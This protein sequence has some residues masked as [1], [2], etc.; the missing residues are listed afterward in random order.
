MLK[1]CLV[2]Y[3]GYGNFGDDV[4]LKILVD[5]FLNNKVEITVLTKREIKE[6]SNDVNQI[7]INKNNFITYIKEF[8]NNDLIIWGGG[9]C[10][11]AKDKNS[12]GLIGLLRRIIIT[13][14]VNKKFIFL[15]VGAE[16]P[17]SKYE[18][19]LYYIISKL[20]YRI[21][22]RDPYSLEILSK[23]KKSCLLINDLTYLHKPEINHSSS[24]NDK[25]MLVSLAGYNHVFIQLD[26][27]CDFIKNLYLFYG[28][29]VRLISMHDG[30][31]D[32]LNLHVFNKLKSTIN[33]KLSN[34]ST[35][36]TRLNEISN[37]YFVLGMRLHSIVLADVLNV[38][39][40]AIS[41]QDKI[42]KYMKS[43][44]VFK[45]NRFFNL[46]DVYSPLHL[47]NSIQEQLESQLIEEHID[48]EKKRII[49]SLNSIFNFG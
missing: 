37:A 4:M 49:S 9:T 2:G 40:F 46:T 34:A 14:L 13:T 24:V 21:I 22:V 17:N 3:Y 8:L 28:I 20:S 32:E 18:K 25:Y 7:I 33:I 29:E 45:Y 42:N 23:F 36:Y 15:G 6:L 44:P 43:L 5:Y 35:M 39:V 10:F 31:D 12:S 1:I 48:R 47:F 19:F 26:K 11:F 30:I 38:P 16:N 41:Y 27:I